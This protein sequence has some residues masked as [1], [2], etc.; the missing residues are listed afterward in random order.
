MIENVAH[1]VQNHVASP[2]V[3]NF[4]QFFRGSVNENLTHA[5]HFGN[6]ATNSINQLKL[7]L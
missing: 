3:L 2:I 5:S 7:I 6:N 4:P 1:E